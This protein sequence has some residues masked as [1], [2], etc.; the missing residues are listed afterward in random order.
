MPGPY[1]GAHDDEKQRGD[2][3]EA[4]VGPDIEESRAGRGDM[5]Q[6]W[7]EG[8]QDGHALLVLFASF[9]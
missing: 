6:H 4:A 5:Q 1:Q 8:T 7:K 9:L 2:T 3:L